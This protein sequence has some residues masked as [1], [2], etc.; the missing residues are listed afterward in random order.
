MNL[1]VFRAP[2]HKIAKTATASERNK[3]PVHI[4]NLKGTQTNITAVQTGWRKQDRG[5]GEELPKQNKKKLHNGKIV[6]VE[7]AVQISH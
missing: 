7:Q 4:I 6:S 3:K 2:F 1:N 5:R